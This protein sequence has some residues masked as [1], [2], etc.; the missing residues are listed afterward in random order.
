MLG[1]KSKNTGKK[2]RA[3]NGSSKPLN[4][5]NSASGKEEK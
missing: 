3:Y 2:K 4:D 1:K 5:A